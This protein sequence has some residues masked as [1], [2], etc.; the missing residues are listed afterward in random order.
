MVSVDS[1]KVVQDAILTTSHRTLLPKSPD[2]VPQTS[3]TDQPVT[4]PLNSIPLTSPPSHQLTAIISNPASSRPC[5]AATTKLL[6]SNPILLITPENLVPTV[7]VNP[8]PATQNCIAT[9]PDHLTITAKTV[10]NYCLNLNA[11]DFAELT[12]GVKLPSCGWVWSFDEQTKNAFCSNHE[13]SDGK[14]MIKSVQILNKN[15]ALFYI[16][17][18]SISTSDL[19]CQFQNHKEL[20][21]ILVTF[22]SRIPCVG[23]ENHSLENIEVSDRCLGMKEGNVWRSKQCVVF[24]EK[25]NLCSKCQNLKVYLMKKKRL[26]P[27]DPMV[28]KRKL[29][30]CQKMVQRMTRRQ[31]VVC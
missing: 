14:L 5:I 10:V 17:G 22:H 27:K 2:L 4:P 31:E 19:I 1:N 21:D 24:A 8:D 28:R 12:R 11:A 13:F 20:S 15:Q 16:N 29:R 26:P 6:S 25:K 9:T 30:T 18:K 3:T 23:I 7:T